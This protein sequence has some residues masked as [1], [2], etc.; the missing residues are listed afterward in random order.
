MRKSEFYR[1][2]A[3][4][5]RLLAD[6]CHDL[7]ARMVLIEAADQWRALARQVKDLGLDTELTVS[8]DL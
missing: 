1:Q 4:E 2:K 8:R 5:C 6:R 3:D 7:T